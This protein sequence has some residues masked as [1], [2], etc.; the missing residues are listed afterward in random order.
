V[1]PEFHPV[2]FRVVRE[3]LPAAIPFVF[4]PGHSSGRVA[5][6]LEQ[7]QQ[8]DADWQRTFVCNWL[9]F[10][11]TMYLQQNGVPGLERLFANLQD[12]VRGM[13]FNH[14]RTAEN[15]LVAR[16]SSTVGSLP[17]PPTLCAS[18]RRNA[19]TASRL[20]GAA[21]VWFSRVIMGWE[22]E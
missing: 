8:D 13:A 11:G 10:D 20:E 5:D 12:R 2:I 3:R 18:Q 9:E 22:E 7:I 15:Q 14:W 17:P 1:L 16:S 21:C 6:A 4:L 19:F